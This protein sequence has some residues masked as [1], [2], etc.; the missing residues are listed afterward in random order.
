LLELFL[1]G[2]KHIFRSTTSRTHPVVREILELGSRRDAV[3]GIPNGG[4]I[5][6][7]AHLADVLHPV[8]LSGFALINPL[9]MIPEQILFTQALDVNSKGEPRPVPPVFRLTG[10]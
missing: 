2:L 9:T 5:D 8:L 1:H 7:S 10:S 6:V 3:V 4:V